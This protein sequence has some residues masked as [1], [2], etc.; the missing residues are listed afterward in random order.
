MKETEREKEETERVER[1]KEESKRK[2]RKIIKMKETE[3]ERER[4][5]EIVGHKKVNSRLHSVCLFVNQYI[6]IWLIQRYSTSLG[7]I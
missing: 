3:R 2:W 6:L 4:E 5:P 1:K 7:R